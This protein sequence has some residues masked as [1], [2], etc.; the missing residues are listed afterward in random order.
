M[1]TTNDL[2]NGMTLDLDGE[3]W[4]VVEFQHVKPGKGGAFVRTKLKNVMS[5]KVVERTF[6]AGVKVDVAAVD[7]REMQYLYKEGGDY[8]FMDT[9]TYDQ[10]HVPGE[11]V[12]DDAQLPAREHDG[13]R[14]RPR[15]HA[16]LHR[17]AGLRRADDHR[18]RARRA[19]RPV[20]GRHQAGTSWRPARR[21]RCSS[22]TGE[23]IKGRH[24]HRRV[25]RPRHQL[26]ADGVPARSKARKRALD[27]LYEADLRGVPADRVLAEHTDRGEPPVPAYAATL[28]RGVLEHRA[29]IDE[30][31]AS[32]AVG[33]T[34]DRMPPVDRNVLRLGVFELL[35]VD[36]VPD[37]VAI[38]EAV[39]LAGS[40]STEDSPRFVNGLLARLA[41][42][43]QR[44][45]P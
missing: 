27:V 20:D 42:A 28:V 10:I 18:D 13:D 7:K 36:E 19:R 1:A 31:L 15:G 38:S 24:P 4:N 37:G 25:P 33:W 45:R 14:R 3:L 35:W 16:A 23:R 39:E 41:A 30:L 8:V 5:G 17:A 12:G 21:C 44:R 22:S 9:E 2:K 6:N 26:T 40:L 43:E 34:L 11:T 29:Q 32:Y